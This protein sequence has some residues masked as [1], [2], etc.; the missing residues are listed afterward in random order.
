MICA[1]CQKPIEDDEEFIKEMN[2]GASLGG[3]DIYL[4]KELC[5]R[6]PQQTYPETWPDRWR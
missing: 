2:F 3:S 6:A 4:H 5:E 1:R